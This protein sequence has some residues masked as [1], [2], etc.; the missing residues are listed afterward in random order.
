MKWSFELRIGRVDSLPTE[1]AVV[2]SAI[3]TVAVGG[4]RAI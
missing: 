3:V 1:L 2:R 4:L